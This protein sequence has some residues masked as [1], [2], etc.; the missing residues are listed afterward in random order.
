MKRQIRVNLLRQLA[1]AIGFTTHTFI[2]RPSPLLARN[3][4]Y[5]EGESRA[6]GAGQYPGSE[7][8]PKP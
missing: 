6:I 3:I 2:Y 8:F 4:G 7:I 1:T 5:V